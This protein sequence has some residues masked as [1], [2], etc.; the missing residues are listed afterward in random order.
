MPP[1]CPCLRCIGTMCL[2]TGCH[3]RSALMQS[4][5]VAD[6]G[7][8]SHLDA[9]GFSERCGEDTIVVSAC[10]VNR[11]ADP[12]LSQR[13][14]GYEEEEGPGVSHLGGKAEGA[15]LGQSR[16]EQAPRGM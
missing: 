11:S 4:G 7:D 16:E 8:R 2:T 5:S 9:L 10:Q 13:H 12:L 6:G 3:L 14:R 1:A 15:A